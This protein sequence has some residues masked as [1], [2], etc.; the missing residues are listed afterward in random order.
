MSK[1]EKSSKDPG[2]LNSYK[3]GT[4]FPSKHSRNCSQFLDVYKRL[5]ND[6]QVLHR[7]KHGSVPTFYWHV[8]SIKVKNIWIYPK[9]NVKCLFKHFMSSPCF[10]GNETWFYH[11]ILFLFTRYTSSQLCQNLCFRKTSKINLKLESFTISNV[12]ARISNVW[13]QKYSSE[14]QKLYSCVVTQDK[15]FSLFEALKFVSCL[16]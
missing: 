4:T 12:F 3:M 13:K 14:P 6:K 11:C 1:T 7:V 5:L 10:I 9:N 16:H 2:I 15:S 8:T